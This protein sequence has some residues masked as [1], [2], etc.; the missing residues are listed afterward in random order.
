MSREIAQQVAAQVGRG[1]DSGGDGGSPVY[2]VTV[3]LTLDGRAMGQAV[4][5][6]SK[7]GRLRITSDAV[8]E[9]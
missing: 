3:P 9:H 2:H 4:F 8:V 7:D 6:L 5:E 1:G